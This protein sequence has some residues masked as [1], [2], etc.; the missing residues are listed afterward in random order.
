MATYGLRIKRKGAIVTDANT[1]QAVI[2]NIFGGGSVESYMD[3]VER[4]N[5]SVPRRVEDHIDCLGYAKALT[6]TVGEDA[7]EWR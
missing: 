7:T 1:A 4:W 2:I 3:E 6:K 5:V